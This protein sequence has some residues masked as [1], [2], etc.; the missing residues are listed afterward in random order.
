MTTFDKREQE[1]ETQFAHEEE[2]KFKALARRTSLLG[3]WAASEMGLEAGAAQAYVKDLL[4]TLLRP[5]ADQQLIDKV[6]SDLKM[7]GKESAAANVRAEIA[8]LDKRAMREV[9]SE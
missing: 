1:F 6:M 9:R 8:A 7:A 2:L 4:D 5:H 3:K